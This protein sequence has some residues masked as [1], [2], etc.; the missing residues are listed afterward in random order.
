[1]SNSG[2]SKQFYA[3]DVKSQSGSF[4][5]LSNVAS[6]NKPYNLFYKDFQPTQSNTSI[7]IV[8]LHNA[9]GSYVDVAKF[10]VGENQRVITYDR[11]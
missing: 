11:Y 2:S 1:M 4:I 7:P 9:T 8:F 6:N 3:V 5:S 10:A